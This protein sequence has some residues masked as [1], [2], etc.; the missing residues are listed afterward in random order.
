VVR[1]FGF[2]RGVVMERWLSAEL[3]RMSARRYRGRGGRRE[4]STAVSR[5]LAFSPGI[6]F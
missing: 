3:K 4:P 5:G 6:F 2:E 1:K